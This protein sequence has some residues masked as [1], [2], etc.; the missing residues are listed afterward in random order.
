MPIIV[1]YEAALWALGLLSVA[2]VVTSPVGQ[3]AARRAAAALRD[4]GY[5]LG[6]LLALDKI[7]EANRNNRRKGCACKAW[8]SCDG[9]QVFPIRQHNGL[10]YQL[11]IANL[12]AKPLVFA[13]APTITSGGP[14]QPGKKGSFKVIEWKFEGAEFDGFWQND[15]TLVEAKDDYRFLDK[16]FMGDNARERE[17]E[18]WMS[19]GL[20]SIGAGQFMRHVTIASK[21]YAVKVE[22]YF[23]DQ[24][25]IKALRTSDSKTINSALA[26]AE[27]A[28]VTVQ[29]KANPYR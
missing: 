26:L 7:A 17:L 28:G 9:E 29:Y 19:A 8:E 3:E 16:G 1:F 12:K 27:K 5:L 22:W 21:H 2:V 20:L 18:K 13:A 10:A 11:Y 6:T 24:E 15:C 25:F 4:L 14:K 23:A